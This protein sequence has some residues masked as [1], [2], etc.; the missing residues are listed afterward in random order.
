MADTYA[1]TES[2]TVYFSQDYHN[3]FFYLFVCPIY[4]GLCAWVIHLFM[5]RY[6]DISILADD[7]KGSNTKH[8]IVRFPLS[9]T[10]ALA[11]AAAVVYGY[12]RDILSIS[13]VPETY[14]FM[15]APIDGSRYL[16]NVGV[17]Y[18]ILNFG[19]MLLTATAILCFFGMFFETLRVGDG[20]AA[21]GK[22]GQTDFSILATRL[23]AFTEA[24]IVAKWLCADYILN[25]TVWKISPLGRTANVDIAY[26]AVTAMGL[27]FISF[28]R[29]Y[30]ELMWHEMETKLDASAGFRDIR[31]PKHRVLANV[32]DVFFIAVF[33]GKYNDITSNKTVVNAL[34]GWLQSLMEM[35][36]VMPS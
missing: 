18:V 28:P 31:G 15:T 36:G 16:N 30:V 12:M 33:L 8:W 11:A 22:D 26:Y 32:V 23:G 21:L 29:Y 3:L 6:R 10:I 7:L 24:Y 35:L 34:N 25:I 17:Y 2:D 4:V 1:G 9:I 27:F 20:V 19:L 13:N 14:W 5:G